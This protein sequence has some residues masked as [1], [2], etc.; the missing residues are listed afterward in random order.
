MNKPF[1]FHHRYQNEQELVNEYEKLRAEALDKSKLS[2]NHQSGFFVL[3]F[4]GMA[5]WI[6]TSLCS[7]ILQTSHGHFDKNDDSIESKELIF[8]DSICKEITLIL[9]NIVLCH[10]KRS[11][12]NYA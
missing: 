4:R 1:Q 2:S 3:F 11:R 6:Q 10:Q 5:S 8:S 7:Q 12:S 9:A